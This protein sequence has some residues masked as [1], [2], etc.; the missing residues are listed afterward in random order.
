MPPAMAPKIVP[1]DSF[2]PVV[3][4]HPAAP[5]ATPAATKAAI[6][7]FIDIKTPETYYNFNPISEVVVSRHQRNSHAQLHLQEIP[8][9]FRQFFD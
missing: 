4:E 5:K 9:I 2:G 1:P 7:D 3:C 6:A 8:T